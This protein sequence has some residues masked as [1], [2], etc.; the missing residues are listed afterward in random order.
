M[1]ESRPPNTT[2]T[3]RE[4][5]VV[6]FVTLPLRGEWV[7]ER[8]PAD[9]IPTHGTNLF[10]QRY[11]YDFVR[12]D[13]RRGR[14]VHPARFFRW[15]LLGGRTRECYGWGQPVH[16]AF[17]GV[18]VTAQD[19]V[20]ERQWLHPAREQWHAIKTLLRIALT[21][22]LTAR[23]VAGN[24]VVVRSDGTYALYAHLAPGTVDVRPG[25]RV[26]AGQVV[27]RVGHTGSSTAPHLH[28]QIMD[29]ADPLRAAG[30]ICGFDVYEALH[31]GKWVVVRRGIPDRLERIRAVA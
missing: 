14:R 1:T 20:A 30:V 25:H 15:L 26:V 7:A 10:G 19:G 27:G 6:A 24:H 8:T 23:D 4:P 9:R 31:D 13:R 17:D 29:N 3:A 18:V 28:F 21:H 11:A 16:A 22:R 12:T 2:E 5:G